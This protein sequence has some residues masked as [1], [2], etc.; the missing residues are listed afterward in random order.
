MATAARYFIFAG[1]DDWPSK[2]RARAPNPASRYYRQSRSRNGPQHPPPLCRGVRFGSSRSRSASSRRDLPPEA[3]LPGFWCI[4]RALS[5]PRARTAFL[6]GGLQLGDGLTHN[7]IAGLGKKRCKTSRQALTLVRLQICG[8]TGIDGRTVAITRAV[9]VL[10][11]G[12]LFR[13]G[14]QEGLSGGFC[15]RVH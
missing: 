10:A 13:A 1:A 2:M 7:R 8:L 12:W 4:A 3:Y 5:L 14:H 6:S 9:A 11:G 15:G